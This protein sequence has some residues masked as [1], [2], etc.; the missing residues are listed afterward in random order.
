MLMPN[1]DFHFT[2]GTPKAFTRQDLPNAVTREFC[3]DC[4]KHPITRRPGP[5]HIVLKIG[6]LDDPTAFKGPKIAIYCEDRQPFHFIPDGL[7]V[8]ETLPDR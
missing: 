1:E 5:D 6:T 8:F 2:K 7:P 4:G 3:A